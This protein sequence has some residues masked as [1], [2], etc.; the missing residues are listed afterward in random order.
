[1]S[2][3]KIQGE[4]QDPG[5]LETIAHYLALLEEAFLVAPLPK[6]STRPARQRSAPPKLG[7]FV[8]RHPKFRPLVLCDHEAR[9]VAERAGIQAMPWTEFLLRG[10]PR[11][12]GRG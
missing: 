10:P 2:L 12:A 4:L 9:P 5:A 8:R 6:H 3:Q 1:M 11:S 7:E